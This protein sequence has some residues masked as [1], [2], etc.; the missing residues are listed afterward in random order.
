MEPVS[1]ALIG[2]GVVVIAAVLG[3][4]LFGPGEDI[5][6]PVAPDGDPVPTFRVVALGLKGAGKTVFLA[7]LFHALRAPDEHRSWFLDGDLR[8]D[9]KLEDIYGHVEDTGANGHPGHRSG[10]RASSCSIARYVTIVTPIRCFA[11][12]IWTMREICWNQ[13]T[14]ST[15]RLTTSSG[16]PWRRMR[17]SSSSMAGVA[18]VLNDPPAGHDDYFE[19]RLSP[20]VGLAGR[21][22]CPVQLLVTKWDLVRA[23]D[24]GGRDKARLERVNDRLADCRITDATF[25]GQGPIQNKVRRI[26]VSA[27]GSGF[28]DLHDDGRTEK[29]HNAK[30]NPMN[31]EVP[32]CAVLPDLLKRV[33]RSL[34]SQPHVRTAIDE[35]LRRRPLRNFA[36]IVQSV[37]TSQAGQALRTSLGTVV[38]DDVVKLFVE[39][40]VRAKANSE[41]SP[42]ASREPDPAHLTDVARLRATVVQEMERAVLRFEARM[43]E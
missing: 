15:R 18:A 36:L 39:T 40:L 7:S 41:Q 29:R 23:A 35:E 9:Q 37:L 5:D 1:A 19:R 28:A 16:G 33:E 10:K 14:R 13:A 17:C 12:A 6:P 22:T 42:P 34:D 27:V 8:Q 26:P 30:L 43:E 24:P 21:A 25:H 38:G 3:R 4:V 32:L 20:L 31:V 11:S 2:S